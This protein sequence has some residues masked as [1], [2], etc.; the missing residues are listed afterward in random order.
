MIIVIHSNYTN[1]NNTTHKHVKGAHAEGAE[2]VLEGQE[3]Q[4]EASKGTLTRSRET[5]N[6]RMHWIL[7]DPG[8][9]P[10][11]LRKVP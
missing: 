7:R 6:F 5:S 3:G 11:A 10:V 1:N 8:K 4:S 9:H 2:G